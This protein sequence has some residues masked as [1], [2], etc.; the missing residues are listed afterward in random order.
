MMKGST[1]IVRYGS[2]HA[3]E[4]ATSSDAGGSIDPN[5]GVNGNK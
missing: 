4:V 1:K 5:L 3:F 2:N